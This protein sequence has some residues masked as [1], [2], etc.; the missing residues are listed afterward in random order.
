MAGETLGVL[1]ISGGHERAHF[2]FVLAAGAA[3]IGRNVVVF[4]TNA[5]VHALAADL[6]AWQGE[7]DSVGAK[8]VATLGELRA[9]AQ[10]MGV[11]MIACE[12]GLRLSGTGE[13]LAEYAEIAGVTT[14]LEAAAPGQIVTL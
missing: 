6:G 4:A 10:E 2:A 7:D 9:A 14:F 13:A 8:G 1:L 12:A 3:A 11:R 5:G